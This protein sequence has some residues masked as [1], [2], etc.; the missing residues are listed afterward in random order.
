[1]FIR[2]DNIVEVYWANFSPEIASGLYFISYEPRNLIS[3]SKLWSKVNKVFCLEP[4]KS[5]LSRF[6]TCSFK[7]WDGR[8]IYSFCAVGWLLLGLDQVNHLILYGAIFFYAAAYKLLSA[9]NVRQVLSAPISQNVH[10]V[11]S[12]QKHNCACLIN[13][14]PI[15][16]CFVFQLR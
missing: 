1:M 8:D 3:I 12:C 7:L 5:T 14:L 9:L 4:R 10:D 6:W 13:Y 2:S 15:G 16:S 11:S